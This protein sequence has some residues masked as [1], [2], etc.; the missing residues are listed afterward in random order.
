[1]ASAVAG[2]SMS[3]GPKDASRSDRFA[4]PCGNCRPCWPIVRL[5]AGRRMGWRRADLVHRRSAYSPLGHRGARNGRVVPCGPPLPRRQSHSR[6]RSTREAARQPHRH[7]A[8]GSCS[9]RGPDD[10][11]P[12]G[13]RRRGQSDGRLLHLAAIGRPKLRDGARR[14]CGPLGSILA[15]ASVPVIKDPK[16]RDK[17]LAIEYWLLTVLV[18][19]SFVAG[20]ISAARSLLD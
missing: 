4:H 20:I 5:H 12:L 2:A 18:A 16:W 1:M 3:L 19:G 14:L 9:G 6:A 7:A 10:A 15:G 8:H 13:W 17:A 11:L